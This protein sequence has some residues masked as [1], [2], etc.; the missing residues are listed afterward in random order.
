MLW[1]SSVDFHDDIVLY[2]V[3]D[4]GLSSIVQGLVSTWVCRRVM[5]V[6]NVAL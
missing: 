6:A 5:F 3:V 1:L 4:M 2:L